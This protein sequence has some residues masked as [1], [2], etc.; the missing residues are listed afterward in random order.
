MSR[1]WEAF[2]SAV[3]RA[4]RRVGK[5]GA[6][7]YRGHKKGSYKLVPSLFRYENG[8][9]KERL[10]FDEF[11]AAG[12]RKYVRR[13][14][15]AS[16]HNAIADD[17]MTLF[18]MQHYAIPTRL[19]DWTENLAIAIAFAVLDRQKDNTDEAALFV[20]DPI[21]LNRISHPK[22]DFIEI[23]PRCEFK[24]RESYLDGDPL[25]PT[26]PVSIATPRGYWNERMVAQNGRFTVHG[27][28][29]KPLDEQVPDVVLRVQIPVGAIGGAK[30]FI[31]D[32]GVTS[33]T[34]FPDI[35]GLAQH[36]SRWHLREMSN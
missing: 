17:W 16:S 2:R 28:E 35:T 12:G 30:E 32:A 36:I 31:R 27:T 10:L 9:E 14:F 11:V 19:L 22:R 24:Y 4:E 34:L 25:P 3:R 20:L 23:T 29:V 13:I 18:D 8:I 26:R 7:W 6:V 33:F 21:G 15:R 1:A 5:H